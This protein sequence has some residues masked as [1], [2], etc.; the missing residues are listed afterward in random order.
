[1]KADKKKVDLAMARA[2]V[3]VRGVSEL[4]NMPPNTIQRMLRGN[5]VRPATIGKVARALGV[6]PAEIVKEDEQ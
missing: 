2:C 5:S 6:D 4:A 3:D 1:M